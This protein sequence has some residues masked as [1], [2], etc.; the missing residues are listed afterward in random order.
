MAST[1][2]IKM[3]EGEA[4]LAVS[5]RSL[6]RLAPTPTSISMNSDPAI[7]KKGTPASPATAL[8][9]SVFPTPAGPVRS[10]PFGVLAPRSRYFLGF[11]RKSTTSSSSF[12][13]SSTPAT[14]ENLMF[15]FPFANNFALLLP[16]PNM[17]PP[18]PCR[19]IK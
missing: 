9:K 6:T 16:I 14:S 4:L 12:L 5:K 18:P 2:S 13:A 11:L 17:S 10:T 1:S 7:E 8:A 15:C 19:F 3:I